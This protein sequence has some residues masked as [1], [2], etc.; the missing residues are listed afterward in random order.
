MS[1]RPSFRTAAAIVA[2]REIKARFLSK[3]FI[4]S[5]LIT[6]AVML[7]VVVLGPRL[8]EIIGATRRVAA[9]CC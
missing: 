9:T 1:T 7:V 5:T 4:I 8:G 3:A 2:R 6:V